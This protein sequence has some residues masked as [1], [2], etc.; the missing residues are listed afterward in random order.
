MIRKN[1]ILSIQSFLQSLIPCSNFDQ[2]NPH[3]IFVWIPWTQ[4]W[5][6]GKDYRSIMLNNISDSMCLRL[7]ILIG[8]IGLDEFWL[9]ECRYRGKRL[10][11]FFIN[12]FVHFFR[13]MISYD[14]APALFSYPEQ[15]LKYKESYK[16]K[17]AD[18]KS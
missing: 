17:G 11:V 2:A 5:P 12:F 9:T 7:E 13:I 16:F 14:Y 3:L 10:P 4:L 8:R 15:R 1:K 6:A 18:K